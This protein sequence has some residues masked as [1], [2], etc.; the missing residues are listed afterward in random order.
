VVESHLRHFVWDINDA[1]GKVVPRTRHGKRVFE[2]EFDSKFVERTL[3]P[4]ESIK[5]VTFNL[6]R[7]FDLSEAGQYSLKITTTC[8]GP[9]GEEISVDGVRFHVKGD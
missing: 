2:E 1:Q 6:A 5:M 9:E 3:R 8:F 4:G 7:V